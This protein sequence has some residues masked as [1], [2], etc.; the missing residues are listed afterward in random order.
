[1]HHLWSKGDFEISSDPARINVE[2]VHEFL[3]NSYWAKGIPME[4]VRRSIEH[5]ICFGMYFAQDQIG[6]ARVISDRATFAYLADVFILPAYRGR[7]LSKWLMECIVAH[8]DLQGLRRWMLATR[9]AHKLYANYGFAP[10]QKPDR[11]MERH[12]PGVYAAKK[13]DES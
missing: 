4:T 5:S 12:D 2:A 3:T 6:F 10:V 7:G 9:D 1:M 13:S 8:P 11:W